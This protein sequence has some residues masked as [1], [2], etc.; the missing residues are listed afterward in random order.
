MKLKTTKHH[1]SHLTEKAVNFLANPIL[2]VMML[3]GLKWE[4]IRPFGGFFV[5][6]ASLSLEMKTLNVASLQDSQ[7]V[8]SFPESSSRCWEHSAAC[9]LLKSQAGDTRVW[10]AD[11]VNTSHT[12]SPGQCGVLVMLPDLKKVYVVQKKSQKFMSNSTGIS[13]V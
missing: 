5:F 13:I 8:L 1:S 2:C 11:V 3:P 7:Y 12:R 4:R 10:F 6:V 9:W